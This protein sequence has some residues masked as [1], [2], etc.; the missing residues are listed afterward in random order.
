MKQIKRKKFCILVNPVAGGRKTTKIFTKIQPLFDTSSVQSVKYFSDRPGLIT[1]FIINTN[2][3]E[4]DGLCVVGGDGTIHEAVLGLMKSGKAKSI[5]LGI[6]PGGTGNAF[7]EDLGCR[8]PIKAAS[9]IIDGKVSPIDIF[10]IVHN[11]TTSY[12]FNIIGWGMASDVNIQAEQLRWLGG[13]RYSISAVINIMAFFKKRRLQLNLADNLVNSKCLFFVALNTI[14]TGKG[15][16]MAPHAKLN[17]GLID[18][19]LVRDVSKLRAVKI[20]TQVFSGNHIF[21]PS[22]EYQQVKTFSIHTK[23]DLLNIDGENTGHTPINV[24]VVPNALKIFAD[25]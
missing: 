15:M 9:Q 2:L 11:E 21:D 24:S 18:T 16:K 25:L 23:G 13:M 19:I 10:Q 7:I 1:D 5:P 8:D 17:D 3:S 20:F 4:F 14:H 22:V 6:I 12:A